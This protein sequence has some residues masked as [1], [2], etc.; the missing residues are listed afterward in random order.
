MKGPMSMTDVEAAFPQLEPGGAYHPSECR[1][2]DRVAI[3]VPYR[4]RE[5]HLAIFL[6]N[7]HRLLMRQQIDYAVFVVEQ[8]GETSSKVMYV[9]LA[10]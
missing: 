8:Q 5:E 7:I 2:R 4:D 10:E 3:I 6:Y 1:A 9:L